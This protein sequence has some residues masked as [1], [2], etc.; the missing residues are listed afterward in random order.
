MFGWIIG[1][2]L[3]TLLLL[4]ALNQFSFSFM[5]KVA[6]YDRWLLLPQWTFFAP[7][8]GCTDYRLLYRDLDEQKQ[9]FEWREIPLV[10]R[11]SYWDGV[12]NPDKRRSKCLFD[13]TQTVVIIRQEYDN[14]AVTMTSIPY[15]ALAHYVDREP[16]QP[17]AKF[18][19]FIV[20][21]THGIFT[22]AGPEPLLRSEVHSVCL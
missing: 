2:V 8:P 18:R 13:L 4:S 21:Q 1:T 11:R 20:V 14:P 9:P 15:L 10:R 19:Q 3:L 5:K 7:N 12:W 22:E 17:G 16:L 6:E